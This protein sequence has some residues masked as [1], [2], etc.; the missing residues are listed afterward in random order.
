[1]T[2]QSTHPVR[3]REREAILQSLRAGVVPRVGLQHIQVGRKPEVAAVLN[4]LESVRDGSSAIRFVIG[5]FGAG[6]SFFLNLVQTVALEKRFVVVRADIT[7]DRRFHGSGGQARAMTAELMRN[8]ATK[9]K[10]DGAAMPNVVEK[11]IAS[12]ATTLEEEGAA[13]EEI[14][15]AIVRT[16]SPLHDLVGGFEFAEVLARYYRAYAADNESLKRA[17]TRWLRA[18]F[19]TKTEAREELGV[20]EIVDDA[21]FYD[22]LKLWA[23]FSRIA[24]YSGLVVGFDE[25]VVLSHRLSHRRARDSNYEQVLRMLNDCLQGHVE[26]LMLLF[27]GTD[28]SLEDRRRG[29][30][31]YEA[32]A[33]RLAPN[34]FAQGDLRDLSSPVIRLPS[35]TAED[36]FVL[37]QRIRRV[38]ASEKRV[39]VDVPDDAIVAYLDYCAKRLGATYFQTPR[40][41]VTRFV[42][43]L[44]VLE[45]NPALDWRGAMAQVGA[46]P[47]PASTSSEATAHLEG[48][49]DGGDDLTNFSL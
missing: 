18:E 21:K 2:Q 42:G 13:A 7:T 45:S 20:R 5:R 6:K 17:A 44:G 34:E 30:Y 1:M 32:L 29:L 39:N 11:W 16:L 3:R 19:G 15:R 43:L 22:Y 36:L 27:C 49:P 40:D 25:L 38:F 31:S 41:A 10:P 24:G 28:E 47:V 9:A 23:A 35:L 4:D 48:S 37:L 26:G 14:E 8:M 46:E 33:T 12:V